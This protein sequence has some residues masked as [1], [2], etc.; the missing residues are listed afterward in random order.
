MLREHMAIHLRFS[1]L[2]AIPEN[3]CL[4]DVRPLLHTGRCPTYGEEGGLVRRLIY[5]GFILR[6]T[7]TPEQSQDSGSSHGKLAAGETDDQREDECKEFSVPAKALNG[8]QIL[9]AAR[10]QTGMVVSRNCLV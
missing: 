1:H 4:S 7:S 6:R 2:G 9:G 3:E 5:I 8:G 10:R